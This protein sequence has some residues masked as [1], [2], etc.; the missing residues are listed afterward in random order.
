M[1]EAFYTH[2]FRRDLKLMAKRGKPIEKF[3]AAAELLIAQGALEPRHRNHRLS[4]GFEGRWECHLES[5]WLLI[6]KL[7][8]TAIV[9]ER[10]G[11]HADLFE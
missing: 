8:A 3:K 5:D 7:S 6:Y 2:Q 9:F 10:T 11:T 1:L 4:G